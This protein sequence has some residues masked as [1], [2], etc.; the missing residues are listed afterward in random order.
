MT[1]E[2]LKQLAEVT[3]SSIA[4]EAR[5][6]VLLSVAQLLYPDNEG[7]VELYKELRQFTREASD[8]LIQE[9]FGPIVQVEDEKDVES[10]SA[11]LAAVIKSAE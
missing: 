6:G 10:A 4:P 1:E 11:T 7:Y 2:Q 8:N 5:F 3:V 9:G